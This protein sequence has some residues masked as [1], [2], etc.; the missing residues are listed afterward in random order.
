MSQPELE[1]LEMF[2]DRFRCADLPG[3]CCFSCITDFKKG[4]YPTLSINEYVCCSH[5]LLAQAK[6][7]EEWFT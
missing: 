7:E 6:E 4:Y 5:A 3:R 1:Q 2:V